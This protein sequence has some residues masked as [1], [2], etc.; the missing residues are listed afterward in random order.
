LKLV[1]S[2]ESKLT[3]QEDKLSKKLDE[4]LKSLNNVILENN[5]LKE[6]VTILEKKIL[7]H[8]QVDLFNEIF[9]RDSRKCNII[10]FNAP[11]SK[12]S[13]EDLNLV[14]SVF[15]SLNLSAKAINTSRLGNSSN[16]PRPLRVNLPDTNCVDQILKSK[17]GLRN[18]PSF[19][20]LNI[21]IDKTKFQQQQYKEVLNEFLEKKNRGDINIRIGYIKGQPKILPKN[22]F[23]HARST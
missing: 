1:K 9:D 11:E 2:L 17:S 14:N 13:S 20:H 7:I 12:N 5:N 3:Q 18:L 15:S 21:D 10:V 19:K 22:R 4:A 23:T 6:K 16:K 8:E